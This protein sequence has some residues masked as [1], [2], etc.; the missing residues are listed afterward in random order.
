VAYR[1]DVLSTMT[2]RSQDWRRV[3]RVILP[4]S[5]AYAGLLLVENI[6]VAKI[7]LWLPIDSYETATEYSLYVSTAAL[8]LRLCV[9]GSGVFYALRV[10][11]HDERGPLRGSFLRFW[12]VVS[13]AFALSLLVIDLWSHEIHFVSESSS[14]E[15]VR[16]LWLAT[17][18]ARIA[19]F[20]IA[21]RFLLGASKV[22]RNAPIGW[23]AAW[24]ATTTLQSVGFFL[25]LLV[26]KLVVDD[27]FVTLLSFVPVISPF[28]FVP[29]EL[30]PMRYFVGQGVQILAQ[31]CGVFLYVAFWIAAD[32]WICPPHQDSLAKN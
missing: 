13:L 29:N 11:G 17:L 15:S 3:L 27:V 32:R 7:D 22:G 25:T 26:I 19:L 18:Y 9:V 21:T 12:C 24:T 2:V 5:I 6:S 20:Y 28:W 8:W 4:F 14:D 10:F 1:T 23:M 16:W 30:S 31:S